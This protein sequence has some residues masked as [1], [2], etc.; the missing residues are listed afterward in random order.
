MPLAILERVF[1]LHGA[2]KKRS[3]QRGS[4]MCKK[5]SSSSQSEYALLPLKDEKVSL[6]M[7][8]SAVGCEDHLYLMVF[9]F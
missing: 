6:L 9:V 7:N 8:L 4:V 2:I 1:T 5:G 3:H